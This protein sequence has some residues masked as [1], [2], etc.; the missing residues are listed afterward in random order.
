MPAGTVNVNVTRMDLIRMSSSVSIRHRSTWI[1]WLVLAAFACAFVI[2]RSGS[3]DTLQELLTL[4]IATVVGATAGVIFA[5]LFSLICILAMSKQSS[6][7]LGHHAYE[8]RDDGLFERT[9]ANDTLIKWG[10]AQDLRRTRSYL[11]IGVSP[12]LYHVIPT[13]AFISHADCEAF[14][15]SIQRLKQQDL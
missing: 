12:G 7:V 5:F 4:L 9:K 6:G 8:L 10:G 3:P 1:S 13:K 14:W 2:Y 11:T 15:Q